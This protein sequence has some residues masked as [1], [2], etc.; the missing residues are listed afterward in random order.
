M[1]EN[2]KDSTLLIR[3]NKNKKEAFKKKCEEAGTTQTKAI[4]R[5]IDTVVEGLAVGGVIDKTIIVGE[6]PAQCFITGELPKGED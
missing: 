6:F 2:K 3:L 1:K 5:F 4:D